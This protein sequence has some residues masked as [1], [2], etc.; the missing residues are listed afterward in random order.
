MARSK[1]ANK[2]DVTVEALDAANAGTEWLLRRS[3]PA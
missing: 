3:T 2:F 1:V